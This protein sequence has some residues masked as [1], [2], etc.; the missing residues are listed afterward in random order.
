M[1][2][3]IVAIIMAV[4]MEMVTT[5]SLTLVHAEGVAVKGKY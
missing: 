3:T 5:I 1:A 4:I 2:T